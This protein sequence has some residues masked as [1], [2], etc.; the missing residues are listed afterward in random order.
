[1]ATVL[2][3]WVSANKLESLLLSRSRYIKCYCALISVDKS[4]SVEFGV[5]DLK[6]SYSIC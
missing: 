4:V 1:M 2:A 5:P 3:V 6:A